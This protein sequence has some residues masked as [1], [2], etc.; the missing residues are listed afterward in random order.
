[1][2][3]ISLKTFRGPNV[4]FE[5]DELISRLNCYCHILHNLVENMCATPAAEK[6]V[7][8]VSAL[9][10]YIRKSG[11]GANCDPQLKK[12]VET[13]W[14][15]VYDMFYSVLLNYSQIG[16]IFLEKEEADPT[17]DIMQKLTVIQR[18][19]LDSICEFLK[20]FKEWSLLLQSDTIPTAWMVWPT[21]LRL[22]KHLEELP[23]EPEIIKSMKAAG[24]NYILK[25]INDIVPKMKHKICTVLNPLLKNIAMAPN[26][27]RKAVYDCINEEIVQH[28]PP[29]EVELETVETPNSELL[30]EFM[31]GENLATAQPPPTP[32]DYSTE[33]QDY[34]GTTITVMDPF[35]IDLVQWWRE[36][37]HQFPRLY[38]LF[39]S[40]ASVMASSAPSERAFSATGIIIE[41]RRA[42]LLPETVS[43]LILSRNKFLNFV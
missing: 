22:K 12:H 30:S 38:R 43:D 20:K 3:N 16:R 33:L 2:H 14:N 4:K 32:S 40:T 23:N 31:G 35:K 21:Y 34:L 18:T 36:H 37:R 26:D 8:D 39:V 41:A 17:A 9:V 28:D 5:D 19:D 25:N 6:V 1:M 24:R 13:R 7:K 15:T 27:E 29:V 10:K 42:N 11:L